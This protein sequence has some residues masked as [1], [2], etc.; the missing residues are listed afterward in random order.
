M[1]GP[2]GCL[3]LH[4][5]GVG[6]TNKVTGWRPS[7]IMP[8]GPP[9]GTSDAL[10]RHRACPSTAGRPAERGPGL[11]IA[12]KEVLITE[13]G[14]HLT[15]ERT[16]INVAFHEWQTHHRLTSAAHTPTKTKRAS[17]IPAEDPASVPYRLTQSKG[18]N[19]PVLV[20]LT[21]SGFST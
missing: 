11:G 16:E 12:A 10:C 6:A 18:L 14:L 3:A 21:V 5:P 9:R 4:P 8:A 15:S 19:K 17:R 20:G 13:D 2:A 7:R 1:P